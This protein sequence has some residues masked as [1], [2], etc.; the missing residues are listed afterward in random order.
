LFVFYKKLFF[1]LVVIKSNKYQPV[2]LKNRNN[3]TND[4]IIDIDFNRIR[5]CVATR[6]MCM[7]VRQ[8]GLWDFIRDFEDDRDGFMFSNNPDVHKISSHPLVE[9]HGHSGASFGI[10]CRNVQFIAKEGLDAWCEKFENPIH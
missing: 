1:L 6:N 8:L 2:K 9:R 4:N 5:S 10:C 7:A 3:M